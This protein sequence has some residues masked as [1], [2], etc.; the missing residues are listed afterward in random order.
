MCLVET[1]NINSDLITQGFQQPDYEIEVIDEDCVIP[2][3]F[4]PNNDEYN[5]YWETPCLK[6]YSDATVKIFNRWGQELFS[7]QSNIKSWDGNFNGQ[8]LPVAD[9]YYVIL[10]EKLNKKLTHPYFIIGTFD[11]SSTGNFLLMPKARTLINPFT[12]TSAFPLIAMDKSEDNPP[13]NKSLA[14]DTMRKVC[15]FSELAG[16]FTL[17]FKCALPIF[18]FPN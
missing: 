4:S 18:I 8:P 15:D 14:E 12:I 2:N 7:A 3:G 16:T 9:Y 5:D 1:V 11:F 17:P 6:N 13:D 10:I